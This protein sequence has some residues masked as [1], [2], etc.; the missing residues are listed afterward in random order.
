MQ[1]FQHQ[2]NLCSV[3]SGMRL[4]V[5]EKCKK[6]VTSNFKQDENENPLKKKKKNVINTQFGNNNK[7][8]KGEQ[9]A[10]PFDIIFCYLSLAS[11][12]FFKAK[13]FS[14]PLFQ[15]LSLP[16]PPPFNLCIQALFFFFSL[17]VSNIQMERKKKKASNSTLLNT[18]FGVPF[19]VYEQI[20]GFEISVYKIQIMQVFKGHNNLRCIESGVGLAVGK[21]NKAC[22][23]QEKE[24]LCTLSFLH[25]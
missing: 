20:F 23:N 18:Y 13:S 12:F 21:T 16:P 15:S 2:D 3:K 10:K 24:K 17:N 14:Y 7:A 6:H 9:G 25:T 4:A 22:E 19:K 5:K 1:V 8:E 11:T